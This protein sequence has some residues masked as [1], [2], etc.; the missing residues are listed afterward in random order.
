MPNAN[1]QPT[2]HLCA[3]RFWSWLRTSA[4]ATEQLAASRQ[5][6]VGP[7]VENQV[8]YHQ[9][10]RS[11]A[12]DSIFHRGQ[13]HCGGMSLPAKSKTNASNLRP[14]GV[15]AGVGREKIKKRSF[16]TQELDE[17]GAL[18]LSARCR[19][20]EVAVRTATDVAS[21]RTKMKLCQ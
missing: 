21:Q 18:L 7:A 16:A 5:V 10:W 12:H 14:T 1:Q 4:Q 3:P 8:F 2:L 6:P 20:A 17:K 9:V 13:L 19:L 15:L 11:T